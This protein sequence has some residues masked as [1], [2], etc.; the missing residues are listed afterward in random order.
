M[1]RRLLFTKTARLLLGTTLL[2]GALFGHL[3]LRPASDSVSID[4]LELEVDKFTRV[5]TGIGMQFAQKK[6]RFFLSVNYPREIRENETPIVK[7]ALSQQ[8]TKW[9]RMALKTESAEF[10]NVPALNNEVSARLVSAGFTIQPDSPIAK[11]KGSRLPVEFLWSIKPS[12]EGKHDIFLDLSSIPGTV[13]YGNATNVQYSVNGQEK[14]FPQSGMIPLAIVVKTV[15]GV[16]AVTVLLAK[17][18]IGLLGF[19]LM[20]PVLIGYLKGRL[21]ITGD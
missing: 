2:A 17:G 16:S 19:I 5:M 7:L 14:Q 1:T 11:P 10:Q 18:A 12:G 20:Y 9:T 21:H 13:D 15:W 8:A 3:F 6:E 4:K